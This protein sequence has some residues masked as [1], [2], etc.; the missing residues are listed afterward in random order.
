MVTDYLLKIDGIKGES[1]DS[2]H[3]DEI[4][5]ESW[6]FGATQAGSLA[7]GGGG[8]VGKVQ[9]QDLNFT[10]RSSLATVKLMD[11]AA[12]GRHITNAILT[13]RQPN[14]KTGE[15]ET[16]LTVTISE[17]LVSSFKVGGPHDRAEDGSSKHGRGSDPRPL[18][19]VALT[20]SK[21]E[22]AYRPQDVKGSMGAAIKSGWDLKKN[23]AL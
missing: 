21:V 22:L 4:D 1:Q 9:F 5:V 10:A 11:A 18:D 20:F 6:S 14:S 2:K 12:S 17:L 19:Q 3:K 8:G 16:Y 15:Q 13:C 23:K 7:Y